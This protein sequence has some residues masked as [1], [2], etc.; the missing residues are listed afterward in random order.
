MTM[1]DKAKVFLTVCIPVTLEITAS[2]TASWDSHA[3]ATE[4]H[5]ASVVPVQALSPRVLMEHMTEDDHIELDRI[6]SKALGKD[7]ETSDDSQ[8]TT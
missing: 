6:V 4:I 2:I 7:D 3:D 5:D 8:E 1:S